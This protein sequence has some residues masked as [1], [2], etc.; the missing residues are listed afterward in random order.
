MLPDTYKAWACH[1]YPTQTGRYPDTLHSSP[2][3]RHFLVTLSP[4][5]FP[6]IPTPH[7]HLHRLTLYPD[8]STIQRLPTV[9]DMLTFC[10]CRCSSIWNA[11]CFDLTLLT[12]TS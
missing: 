9:L 5:L 1:K 2:L 7:I 3:T 6:F 12:V 10:F 8:R 4:S 11:L